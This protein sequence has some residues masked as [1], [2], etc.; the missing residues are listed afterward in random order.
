MLIYNE[1]MK[2]K[3]S[4]T[5]DLIMIILAIIFFILLLAIVGMKLGGVFNAK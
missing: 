3:K 4:M 1:S 5:S 2:S